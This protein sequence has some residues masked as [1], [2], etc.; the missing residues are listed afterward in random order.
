MTT[1]K[2]DSEA[3]E[4]R[5]LRRA[6]GPIGLL[7][8]SVG[9][10]IGSGWLF[11]ALNAAQQAGP[12]SIISWA[13]GMVMILM[14]GLVYAE[15][16]AMFPLPGGVVR[17]PHIAFGSFASFSAGWITWVAVATTAPIEVEGALQYATK[18]AAFTKEHT[19]DGA[20]VHT[21]TP[22]G[23]GA[24]VVLMAVF[25]VINYIGI[26]WFSRINNVLVWWKLAVIMLVV[27]AFL[28]TAFHG[29]NFTSHEFRPEGWKGVFTAIATSGI[30]FSFLGFRQAVELAGESSRPKRD[31]P[32]AVIG[33]ILIT[34]IIYIGLEIAFI[35][36][37]RPS[38][39]A[40]SHGWAKLSFDNDFG[41]L[42]AIASI[43]GLGW[44]AVILYIDAIVS[45]G[46]TGLIYTTVTSRISYAMGMNGNAPKALASTTQRGV[47]LI[48]LV[49]AFVI[50]LIVFLPFPS[51]QQLVGF[52]TSATVL[53]FGSG[54][55]VLG[56]LRRSLPDHERPFKLPGG[57]LIPLL[58]FWSANL[59]VYW[60]G[61]KTDWKL[62]VAIL[63]G[64]VLLAVM[65]TI[66]VRTPP[67][68]WRSGATWVLPWM[69][70]LALMSYLGDYDGG[71]GVIG[72]GS[73]IP[74]SLALTVAIYYLGMY[75][76]LDR[77][78]IEQHIED[79]SREAKSEEDAF[80]GKG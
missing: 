2:V 77:A 63:L 68:E 29:S 14:I 44:L 61:W 16:G 35:G 27:V 65:E 10:I 19:V 79:A 4:S 70:G 17:F 37:V 33:S 72:F 62:F 20:P 71:R 60:T 54:P 18:Y 11:G 58:A 3:D 43:I 32:L 22:L 50:G 39:L 55:L 69:G 24:A 21:L 5:S 6:V 80:G 76:R 45:P 64:Y 59:I 30:I 31:V 56:A 46:D 36:S 41:P 23:Y 66:N 57:D 47:P 42:A 53:S 15:L 34:G 7:F 48:G 78:T 28:V 1:S 12:A 25:V 52:I 8:T 49:V 40:S 26:R 67:L 13:I 73:A 51:W 74:I 38:D 9:S 75:V